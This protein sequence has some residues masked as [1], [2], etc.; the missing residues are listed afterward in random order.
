PKF[1][2]VQAPEYACWTRS[3]SL[4]PTA[5]PNIDPF[6][7]SQK[8]SVLQVVG[9]P[10]QSFDE[11]IDIARRLF[12]WNGLRLGIHPNGQNVQGCKSSLI[13]FDIYEQCIGTVVGELIDPV[14]S[15]LDAK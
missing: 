2:A 14:R 3:V 6:A 4:R 10:I 7:V 12:E 11:I 15:W 9:Q 5:R 1:W 13:R 8:R